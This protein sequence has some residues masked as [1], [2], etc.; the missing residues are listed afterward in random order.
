M[1]APKQFVQTDGT[2]FKLDGRPWC[3]APCGFLSGQYLNLCSGCQAAW[4]PCMS[5][6]MEVKE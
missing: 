4:S 6:A 2:R 1:Q 3:A 5:T